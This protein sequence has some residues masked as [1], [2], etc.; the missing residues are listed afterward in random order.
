M[1][2]EAKISKDSFNTEEESKIENE[3]LNWGSS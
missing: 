1:I 3:Y 2:Y